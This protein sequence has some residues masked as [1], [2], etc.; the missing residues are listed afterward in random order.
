VERAASRPYR[1]AFDDRSFDCT[2]ELDAQKK[3][4]FA[5]EQDPLARQTFRDQQP[6]VDPTTLIV[7]DECGSNINLTPRYARSP[8][9]EQ[10]IGYVP[11]NTPVNT[12][13]IASLTLEGIGPSL[14]LPGATDRL[15]F[16][17]YIEH[18]LAPTLRPGQVIVL[19]NLR[20][21]HAKRVAHVIEER[22]CRLWFLPSYSPDFSPIEN[23]FAKLKQNWRKAG[24]RTT[25][26]LFDVIA[27]S[28]STITPDDA[29]GFFEH[30][31]YRK[32][33]DQAQP[34]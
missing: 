28:L 5:S 31:G 17:T 2:T 16:E 9:G 11:R 29:R 30:C 32:L 26:A 1:F 19:D 6:L 21:H 8:R 4:V 34:L 24:V 20:V 7:L 22:G 12:T 23:A 18:V 25:D 14:V 33:A 3:T 13:L 15:A 10:A 27:N